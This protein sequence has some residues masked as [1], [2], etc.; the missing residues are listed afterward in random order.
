MTELLIYT[1]ISIVT[2]LTPGAGVLYTLTNAFRH[3]K[4]YA[5]CSPCGNTLGVIIMSCL[6][7]A[8]TGAVIAASPALFCA[9]QGAGALVLAWMGW[10]SFKAP[11]VDLAARAGDAAGRP[12]DARTARRIFFGATLLQAT[13][14]MLITFL[15]SFVPAFIHE[16]DVYGERIAVLLAIF[17]ACCISVHLGYSYTAACAARLL[18]GERLSFW[19]NKVS[20][21]LFW[22]LAA[23]VLWGL[24]QKAAAL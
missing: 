5:W 11:A 17:V 16:G 18:K 4:D 2:V 14:P 19:L 6:T 8:G 13:N 10:R 12:R 21:A 9:L 7:A 1:A 22:L 23:S 24:A 15:L 20:A 3:G